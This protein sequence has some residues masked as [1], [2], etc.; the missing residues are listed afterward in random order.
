MPVSV[1]NISSATGFSSSLTWV[2][3]LGT[4]SDLVLVVLMGT[5]GART[6]TS[7][8]WDAD[9]VN[10][11]LTQ[12]RR[13]E[14][15]GFAG[16]EIWYLVNPSVATGSS[17]V[18][19]V[20]SAGAHVQGGAITFLGATTP[21]NAAGSNADAVTSASD[22]VAGDAAD[23]FMVDLLRANT[24][25]AL[26]AD[27]TLAFTEIQESDRTSGS[28]QDGVDGG[29]MSWTFS[30][31]DMCHTACRIPAAAAAAAATEIPLRRFYMRDAT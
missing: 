29:I 30:S 3:T 7:V 13:D 27:Q 8:T 6:V 20:E 31:A 2:H 18:S 9:G 26:G 14:N 19:T 23:N 11:S 10:Q 24:T 22:T 17:E 1:G 5:A 21:D 25:H 16:T 4:G 12:L 15:V 28:T